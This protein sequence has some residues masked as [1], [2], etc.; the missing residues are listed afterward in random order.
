MLEP[1]LVELEKKEQQAWETIESL[2]KV[3]RSHK[4]RYYKRWRHNATIPLP[5]MEQHLIDAF[6]EWESLRNE[7]WR[8]LR[9]ERP[10]NSGPQ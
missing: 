9:G 10:V 5:D 7:Y 8:A 2:I 6:K 1:E 3:L 4:Q